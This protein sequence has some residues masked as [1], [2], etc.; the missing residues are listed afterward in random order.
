VKTCSDN[1]VSIEDEDDER[2]EL[3]RWTCSACGR[4]GHWTPAS[5]RKLVAIRGHAHTLRTRKKRPASK[6]RVARSNEYT[7]LRSLLD[8]GGS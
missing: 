7:A 4:A 8:L 3:C 6:G 1:T 5:E 2:G